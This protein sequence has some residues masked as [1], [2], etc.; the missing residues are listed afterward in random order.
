MDTLATVQETC[1]RVAGLLRSYLVLGFHSSA[2]ITPASSHI[3]PC[4]T[5]ISF[6]SGKSGGLHFDYYDKSRHVE[7][8]CYKKRMAQS[9]GG[10]RSSQGS[11]GS[12]YTGGQKRSSRN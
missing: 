6:R 12:P 1:L 9:Y 2:S 8:Y 11:V 7:D 4:S 5:A 3:L 10:G